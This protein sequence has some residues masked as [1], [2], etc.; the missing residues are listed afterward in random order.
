[1]AEGRHILTDE[2]PSENQFFHNAWLLQRVLSGRRVWHVQ[3]IHGSL[4]L[5]PAS[6]IA[7]GSWSALSQ[8]KS[9]PK[10]LRTGGDVGCGADHST[11]PR[12]IYIMFQ[13]PQ[14]PKKRRPRG[15]KAAS[16][17]PRE[18]YHP[19]PTNTQEASDSD[20]T[21]RRGGGMGRR[22]VDR[23]CVE[24]AWSPSGNVLG[25]VWASS[26]NVRGQI[27]I[28]FATVGVS[29]G[30]VWQRLGSDFV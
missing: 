28:R 24:S 27:G 30:S 2:R 20:P 3:S 8:H 22:P 4:P 6:G 9:G 10:W 12:L 1:M 19:T 23:Q 13:S 11:W 21:P 17:G 29:L 14:A 7:H 5:V 16:R 26:G 18:A 25:F 15:F